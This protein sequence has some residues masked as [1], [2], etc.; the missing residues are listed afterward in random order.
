MPNTSFRTL[1]IPAW[2]RVLVIPL[3]RRGGGYLH[4]IKMETP[5]QRLAPWEPKKEANPATPRR[6][7]EEKKRLTQFTKKN[8]KRQSRR[9]RETAQRMSK[10]NWRNPTSRL[11][12][13]E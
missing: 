1:L 7:K 9:L 4:S 6:T 5:H 2:C 8:P 10:E 11:S 12:S 13:R 3:S